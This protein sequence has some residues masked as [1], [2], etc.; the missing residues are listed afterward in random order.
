MKSW[1]HKTVVILGVACLGLSIAIVFIS[2][3]NMRIQSEIQD[4]QQQLN[5]GVLGAEAQQITGR[6]LQDM[7][8]TA[9]KNEKMRNLLTK[10]GYNVRSSEPEA[11]TQAPANTK[12]EN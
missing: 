7:G 6:I 2:Q 12:E 3:R 9:A 4:R 1:Q 10:Y 8:T 11:A 5:N